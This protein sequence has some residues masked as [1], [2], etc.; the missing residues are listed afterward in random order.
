MYMLIDQRTDTPFYIGSNGDKERRPRSHLRGNCVMSARYVEEIQ[1]A[2]F[3]PEMQIIADGLES[4]EALRLTCQSRTVAALVLPFQQPSPPVATERRR[5]APAL[6]RLRYGQHR[7]LSIEDRTGTASR[8][9]DRE[10]IP[11]TTFQ[12]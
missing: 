12:G 7:A 2:G 1:Q 6:L 5:P 9:R 3:T 4:E 10:S 11:Y 8:S